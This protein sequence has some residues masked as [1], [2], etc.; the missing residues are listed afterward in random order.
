[1]CFIFP[2][3]HVRYV[4]RAFDARGIISLSTGVS[5]VLQTVFFDMTELMFTSSDYKFECGIR[6][7]AMK[8]VTREWEGHCSKD[9]AIALAS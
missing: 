2:V 5:A 6:Q 7:I 4:E 9:A 3:S 8:S 1:M